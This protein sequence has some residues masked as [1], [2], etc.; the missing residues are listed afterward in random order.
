MRKLIRDKLHQPARGDT[1]VVVGSYEHHALLLAKLHEEISELAQSE[2][3]DR[4]EYGDVMEVL[5]ALATIH[6]LDW[7]IILNEMETK[8]DERGSFVAG[9]VMNK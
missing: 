3:L 5:R 1:N 6:C 7:C 4:S 2:F 9:V 8:K